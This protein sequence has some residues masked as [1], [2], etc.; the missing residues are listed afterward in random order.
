MLSLH[1]VERILERI[2]PELQEIVLELRN[3]VAAIAPEATEEFRNKGFIIY[4]AKRGGPV[5][6]GI[7][8]ILIMGDHIKL[9]FIHGAFL[10]DPQG[11]LDGDRKAKKFVR[12]SSYDA[13]P[14]E[15]LRDLIAASAKFDP[16]TSEAIQG[17]MR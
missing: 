2:P 13:A 3:I 11:L 12:I 16:H 9:A 4:N 1:E 6:A 17:L 14:W 7:C 15:A 5:S 10:L 8:Q